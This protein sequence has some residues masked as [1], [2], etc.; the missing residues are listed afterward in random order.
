[1]SPGKRHRAAAAVLGVSVLIGVGLGQA[2]PSTE[3]AWT[4][5]ERVMATGA[6][7]NV[8]EP[9]TTVAPGC[10]A[11]SGLLGANP[12]VTLSWRAPATATGYDLTK[13]EFG[14]IVNQGLLEPILSALLGNV[15]TTGTSSAY[16]TVIDGGLLTGLLGA[17]KTFGVRFTGPGGWKSDWLVA[18]AS[19]GLLGVN[20]QCSMSTLPSY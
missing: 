3:A 16:V 12:K 4:D 11:S 10:V 13:A 9:I 2:V 5:A 8:P 19:M 18:N 15:Q 7:I 6:A 20:P 17:A 14:Q 1:M